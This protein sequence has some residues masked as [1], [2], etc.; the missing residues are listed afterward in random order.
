MSGGGTAEGR[1]VASGRRARLAESPGGF[2][3]QPDVSS[4]VV[5]LAGDEQRV[6]QLVVVVFDL[7]DIHL[8]GANDNRPRDAVVDTVTCS[9]IL[10]LLRLTE[11][12]DSI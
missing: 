4:V 12:P 9:E 2:V 1:E 7:G 5:A 6:E 3:A 8:S 11:Y 10:R